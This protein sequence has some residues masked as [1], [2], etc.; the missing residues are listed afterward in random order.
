VKLDHKY[1]YEID[2]FKLLV[3]EF[4]RQV[5]DYKLKNQHY[6]NETIVHDLNEYQAP[7]YISN[8]KS[9]LTSSLIIEAQGLL[10]F[11]LPVIVGHFA[12]MKN[13]DISPFKSGNVLCWAKNTLKN[14]IGSN[15]NFG[16]EPHCKL[17]E[18][19]EF[20]NDHIHHGGYMSSDERRQL[21]KANSGISACEFTDLYVV[22]FS[23]CRGVITYIEKY[24][25]G[26]IESFNT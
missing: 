20:R 13:K 22:D 19:Y 25:D 4:E 18:F 3:D 16:T 7:R 17:K 10:D 12:K 1:K 11:F 23:Y 26:I 2:S 9:I 21:L 8:Y 14:K 15:Y 5:D 24:F 6:V